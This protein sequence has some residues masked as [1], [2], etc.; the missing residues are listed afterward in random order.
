MIHR[1]QEMETIAVVRNDGNKLPREQKG[2]SA[3]S[4]TPQAA[5]TLHQP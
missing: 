1:L 3:A 5:F 4:L 2:V